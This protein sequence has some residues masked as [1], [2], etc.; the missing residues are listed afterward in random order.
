MESGASPPF[1][2]L[3]KQDEDRDCDLIPML[4]IPIQIAACRLQIAP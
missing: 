1:I 3:S 2:K 4:F